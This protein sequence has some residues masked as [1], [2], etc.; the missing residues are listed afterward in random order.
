M[1]ASK[2]YLN[3]HLVV[4]GTPAEEGGGG[5]ILML[6]EGVF[7]GIDICMMSH[8]APFEIPDA[9]WLGTVGIEFYFEGS[10]FLGFIIFAIITW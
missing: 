7:D 6:D 3:I 2:N 10:R 1:D 5:K 9:M 4:Y 8:P